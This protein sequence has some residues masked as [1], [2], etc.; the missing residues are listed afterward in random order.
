MP[1]DQG[2]PKR[3]H[4]RKMFGDEMIGQESFHNLMVW[5][6]TFDPG[7]IN[8]IEVAFEIAV[9]LQINSVKLKK[10]KGNYKGIWPQEANNI[11]EQFLNSLPKGDAFYFFDY[12]LTS[13]AS[14]K[15]TIG[16][17]YVTL[18]LDSSWTGHKLYRNV[19]RE[20]LE[21]E[22]QEKGRPTF[23]PYVIQSRQPICFSPLK[24]LNF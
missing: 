20:I 21:F 22:K 14:W 7:Q 8:T 5:K 16:E 17:Q 10:V 1:K 2:V 13:G 23:F 6:E 11:P 9:P 3:T 24:G 12:Y 19:G 15:G 4:A 18:K